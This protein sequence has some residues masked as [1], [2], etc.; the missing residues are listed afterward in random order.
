MEWLRLWHDFPTDPK[1]RVI[2][3]KASGI[4]NVDPEI[5]ISEV[6]A[7]YAFLLVDASSNEVKRG[8]T[9]G[10]VSED[11]ASALDISVGAVDAIL[12]AMQGKVLDGNRITG[13]ERRQV[14]REDLSTDRVREHRQRNAM[15]RNETLDKKRE[16]EIREEKRKNTDAAE[17]PPT[18]GREGKGI[19]GKG[20]EGKGSE[21]IA[22]PSDFQTLWSNYPEAGRERFE[23]SNS[24]YFQIV[25]ETNPK[26]R[27]TDEEI[28]AGLDRWKL[29][30]R[31]HD[32]AT[33]T[34]LNW[35]K[36][37]LFRE[38]PQTQAEWEALK[39]RNGKPPAKAAPPLSDREKLM[40][41]EAYA[42]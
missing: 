16:E 31:W 35:L 33:H 2:A 20:S 37:G 7:V 13:W 22:Q 24:Y 9:H 11:V 21:L 39:E 25:S 14:K 41:K 38:H 27:A 36:E 34:I 15:K 29:S 10:F 32:G 23:L 28:S 18:K 19:E 1:W 42:K 5:S 12:T 4:Y 26:K 3:R 30:H 17:K 6:M 8:E 40:G